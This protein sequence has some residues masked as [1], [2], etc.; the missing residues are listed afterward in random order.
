MFKRMTQSDFELANNSIQRRA[1]VD[2]HKP[3]NTILYYS[4]TT[5]LTFHDSLHSTS[6]FFFSLY[7]A[8]RIVNAVA[9]YQL[10]YPCVSQEFHRDK[11]ISHETRKLHS[12]FL[13]SN[14]EFKILLGH[15]IIRA[16]LQVFRQNRL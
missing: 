16:M 12:L 11:N 5:L 2:F 1:Q 8:S 15:S 6:L 14:S 9:C 3:L 7:M 13:N 4:R 10:Q